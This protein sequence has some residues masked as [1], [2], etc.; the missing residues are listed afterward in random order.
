MQK[1]GS[2]F[3]FNLT[4]SLSFS[5]FSNEKC[6][7]MKRKKI[8]WVKERNVCVELA[9][10]LMISMQKKLLI[11]LYDFGRWCGRRKKMGLGHFFLE[12]YFLTIWKKRE[13]QRG[14]NSLNPGKFNPFFFGQKKYFSVYPM[15]C[16]VCP[17]VKLLL[18]K[19]MF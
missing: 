17:T 10:S 13:R 14:K 6:I 4:N 16:I 8:P 5:F 18:E 11:L 3:F 1:N 9:S 7:E 12:Q 15:C 19:K 2:L